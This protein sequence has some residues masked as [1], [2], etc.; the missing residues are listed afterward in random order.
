MVRNISYWSCPFSQHRAL[1]TLGI[2]KVLKAR[3]VSFVMFCYIRLENPW[4]TSGQRL[5]SKRT[6]HVIRG[7]EL[8]S[9]PLRSNL[10][11]EERGWQCRSIANGQ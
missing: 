10:Q 1:K 7:L 11:G 4:V 5:V 3:K 6:N 9:P 8:S 2:S